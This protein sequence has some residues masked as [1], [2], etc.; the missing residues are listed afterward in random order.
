MSWDLTAVNDLVGIIRDGILNVANA[1][2][3]EARENPRSMAGACVLGCAAGL[4]AG[5]GVAKLGVFAATAGALPVLA[6][7]AIG[8]FVGGVIA[9]LFLANLFN[10]S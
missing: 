4:T 1:I 9:G 2:F 3:P 10:S 8:I 5:L 7:V 6:P